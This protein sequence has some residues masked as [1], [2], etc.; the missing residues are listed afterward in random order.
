MA[1]TGVSLIIYDNRGEPFYLIY[2]RASN[3][4][5]WEFPK[6]KLKEGETP[7]DA[8]ARIFK[9]EAGISEFKI[10]KRLEATRKY[11]S[12]GTEKE[13]AVFIVES[14]MNIPVKNYKSSKKHDTYIWTKEPEVISKLTWDNEKEL[15]KKVATELKKQS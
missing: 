12:N 9:Q 1:I 8:A 11:V 3:W 10:L 13:L 5:G 14:N 6:G 7:E 15:F 2:R 4:R